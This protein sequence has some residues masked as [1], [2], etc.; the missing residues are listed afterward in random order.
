MNTKNNKKIGD[1]GEGIA[2]GY[3][4]GKGYKILARN[5]RTKFGEIDIIAKSPLKTL[6]F[7]EVKTMTNSSYYQHGIP[8]SYP[9]ISG[10]VRDYITPEDHLSQDKLSKFRRVSEWYAN[11]NPKLSEG[12]YQLDAICILLSPEEEVLSLKH[13]KNV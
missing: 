3:L 12:G 6:I 10:N 5:I 8:E 9:H 13:L 7:I 11:Q 2:C 1:I 4:G